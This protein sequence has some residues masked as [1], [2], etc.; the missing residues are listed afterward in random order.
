MVDELIRLL[1]VALLLTLLACVLRWII[2]RRVGRD[3]RR[4]RGAERSLERERE[5]GL[6]FDGDYLLRG[7]GPWDQR[8]TVVVIDS[9]SWSRACNRR[10]F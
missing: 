9:R 8:G 3:D 7:Y 10:V 1:E 5:C 2:D 6:I 4:A